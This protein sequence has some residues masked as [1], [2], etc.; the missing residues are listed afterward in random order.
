M[1]NYERE[2][3]S[4]SESLKVCNCDYASERPRWKGEGRIV[5]IYDVDGIGEELLAL[6]SNDF[7]PTFSA[8]NYSCAPPPHFCEVPG[9][10]STG[11]FRKFWNLGYLTSSWIQMV[12]W[13]EGDGRWAE[14]GEE[15]YPRGPKGE[16][17]KGSGH[18]ELCYVRDLE[19]E[20]Q[21]EVR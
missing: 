17:L 7:C 6:V 1:G 10:E 20:P 21:L 15:D 13:E 14:F 8:L 18:C 11:V 5:F 4:S 3:R 2:D 19:S 16:W 9:L 12:G